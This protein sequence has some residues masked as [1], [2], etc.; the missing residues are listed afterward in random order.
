MNF[1]FLS[2]CEYQTLDTQSEKKNIFLYVS[3]IYKHDKQKKVSEFST[4]AC[5]LVG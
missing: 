3:E 1:S 2:Y 4:L 5:W